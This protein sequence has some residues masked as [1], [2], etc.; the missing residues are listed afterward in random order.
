MVTLAGTDLGYAL[1]AGLTSGPAHRAPL[2]AY[3]DE[4]GEADA[5][6]SAPVL[7]LTKG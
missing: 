3:A 6:A 2:V 1:K 5:G 7:P 4:I